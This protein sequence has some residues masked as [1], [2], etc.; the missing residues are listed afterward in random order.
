MEHVKFSELS[1]ESKKKAITKMFEFKQ[2]GWPSGVLWD[3]E[4]DIEIDIVE[5][6]YSPDSHFV[7]TEEGGV[8]N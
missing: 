8:S 3:S 7:F 6:E 1:P 4:D 2:N 5:H